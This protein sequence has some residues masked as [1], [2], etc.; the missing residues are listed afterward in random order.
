MST[1]NRFTRCRLL[2]DTN[3]WGCIYK[4]VFFK[5]MFYTV[6]WA[7]V[8]FFFFSFLSNCANATYEP[9]SQDLRLLGNVSLFLWKPCLL[10]NKTQQNLQSVLF[11]V[12]GWGGWGGG[13]GGYLELLQWWENG[14]NK[15]IRLPGGQG[16][17]DFNRFNKSQFL[18][19]SY[20]YCEPSSRWMMWKNSIEQINCLSRVG[21]TF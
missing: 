9:L 19:D 10:L 7:A 13:G 16:L 5:I 1:G 17:K 20:C 6:P 14:N 2:I 8:L 3:V 4:C 12:R 18:L 15:D 21:P 11:R